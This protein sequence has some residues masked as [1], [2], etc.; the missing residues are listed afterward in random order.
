MNLVHPSNPL[1][2]GVHIKMPSLAYIKL[3][4]RVTQVLTTPAGYSAPTF[5]LLGPKFVVQQPALEEQ[6]WKRWQIT[7]TRRF[8]RLSGL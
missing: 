8:Y 1:C 4:R 6:H 5:M 3:G 2:L 7:L